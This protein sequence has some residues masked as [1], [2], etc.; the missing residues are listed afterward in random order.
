MRLFIIFVLACASWAQVQHP[1]VYI[2]GW[3]KESGN[4]NAEQDEFV[5]AW[6]LWMHNAQVMLDGG[7][8]LLEPE[9]QL[10]PELAQRGYTTSTAEQAKAVV[11]DQRAMTD[12]LLP[13]CQAYDP[14]AP[15]EETYRLAQQVMEQV[16]SLIIAEESYLS[17]GSQTAWQDMSKYRLRAYLDLKSTNEIFW[18]AVEATKSKT[19]DDTSSPPKELELNPPRRLQ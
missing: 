14:P 19:T 11:R 12:E 13:Q 9:L 17:T 5:K 4:T 8:I 15:F 16:D 2:M 18:D 3:V 7:A 10:Q 6:F 1:K